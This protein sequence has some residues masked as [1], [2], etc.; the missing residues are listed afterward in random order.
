MGKDQEV[1]RD[2][3]SDEVDILVGRHEALAVAAVPSGQDDLIPVHR[4]GSDSIPHIQREGQT[5]RLPGTASNI[6]QFEVAGQLAAEQKS[7]TMGMP[8]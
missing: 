4:S 8:D 3:S 1:D 2:C 7:M 6:G 5:S